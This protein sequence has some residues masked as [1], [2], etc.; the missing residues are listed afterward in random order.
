[1]MLHKLR[2]AM[3]RPGRDRLTG[4]IEVDEAYVGGLEEGVRGRQTEKKSVI[5]VAAQ[6]DESGISRIRMSHVDD[7]SIQEER[8]AG[9]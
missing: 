2:S 1:M 8:K 5:V 4:T 9:P 7:A 3:V 6:E